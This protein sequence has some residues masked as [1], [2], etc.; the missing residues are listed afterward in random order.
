MK[1]DW[2][3]LTGADNTKHIRQRIFDMFD[4]SNYGFRHLI[5]EVSVAIAALID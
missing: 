1:P 3:M 4:V 5:T 2:F